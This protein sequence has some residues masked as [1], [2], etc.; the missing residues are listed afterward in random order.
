MTQRMLTTCQVCFTYSQPHC[1]AAQRWAS[2]RESRIDRCRALVEVGELD[3]EN[4]R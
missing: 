4:E 1:E 3:K 2:A